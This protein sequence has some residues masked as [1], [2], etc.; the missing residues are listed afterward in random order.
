[1]QTKKGRVLGLQPGPIRDQKSR[2]GREASKHDGEV[3][4]EVGGKALGLVA[5]AKR[6][7]CPQG[8]VSYAE[9]PRN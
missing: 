8:Q 2:T 5:G 4:R 6:K 1:M 3:L 9:R 7:H